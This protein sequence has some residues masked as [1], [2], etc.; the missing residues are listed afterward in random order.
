MSDGFVMFWAA[1]P[2]RKARKDAEKAWSQVRGD[3]HVEAILAALAWQTQQAD[4]LKEGGQFVPYPAS[5]LRGERWTDEPDETPML[6]KQTAHNLT[7]VQRWANSK[8]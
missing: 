3:D 8:A 4:W 6:K 1:Y 5:Y 2:K 7:V